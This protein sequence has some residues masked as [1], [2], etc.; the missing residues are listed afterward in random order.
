MKFE[1]AIN[2]F[3]TKNFNEAIEVFLNLKKKIKENPDINFYLGLCYFELNSFDKSIEYLKKSIKIDPNFYRALYNLAL[4]YQTLG[5]VNLAKNIYF[6]L[7]KKN[8]YFVRPYIGL[9]NLDPNLILNSH[10]LIISEISKKEKLSDFEKSM[11]AFIL[12]KNEKKKKNYKTELQ[13][14]KKYHYLCFNS[15][16]ALNHQSEFYYDKIISR[17]YNKIQFNNISDKHKLSTISP[18]FIIGLPRSGSTLIETIL[19]SSDKKLKSCGESNIFNM[20]IVE[21]IKNKI[22]SKSFNVNEKILYI[23]HLK[24]LENLKKKYKSQNILENEIFIDKSLENFFNIEVILKIL[25]NAKFIHTYRNY[26]D[27]I[28]SIYQ[29]S[30]HQLSWTHKIESITKYINNYLM[31]IKFFKNKYKNK[32]LDV[33]LE[34]LSNSEEK[35]FEN[36]FNFC[37]IKWDKKFLDLERRKTSF[38]KTLSGMQ[39]RKKISKYDNEKYRPYYYLLKDYKKKYKWINF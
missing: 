30:L 15:N 18:I 39:V 27:S 32:I 36:I 14:L 31:I 1:D 35:V 24:I 19:T 8:K 7:L 12:S 17:F 34:D 16:L 29:S 33:S 38:V 2:L 37:S 11:V 3:R 23:D 25:P 21:N 13:Y 28:L 26:N 4:V 20:C 6:N 22:F 10:Y 5:K 9:Y